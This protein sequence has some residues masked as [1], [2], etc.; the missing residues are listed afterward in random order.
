P[1][2][3]SRCAKNLRTG[4]HSRNDIRRSPFSTTGNR[5]H[6]EPSGQIPDG[7]F[8]FYITPGDPSGRSRPSDRVAVLNA[9]PAR[10]LPARA[11]EE[12]VAERI[13]AATA[14]VKLVQ[15]IERSLRVRIE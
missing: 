6:Q 13:T 3:R 12:L 11:L 5:P 4:A 8:S 2:H 9:C 1:S 14:D 15:H 7:V 10:P